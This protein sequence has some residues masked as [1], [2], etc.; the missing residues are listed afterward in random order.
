[1]SGA[2]AHRLGIVTECVASRDELDAAVTALAAKLASGGPGALR[3]TKSLLNQ[4]DGSDDPGP[5][6]RGAVL[7]A[8][9][10]ATPETQ[11]MLRSKM[12]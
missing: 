1:M 6:R 12:G 3:A 11:A 7:S 8:A 9:V 4:L 10:L 2:D 5:V